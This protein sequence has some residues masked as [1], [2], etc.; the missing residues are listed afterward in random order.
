MFFHHLFI[1]GCVV[2]VGVFAFPAMAFAVGEA[3]TDDSDCAVGEVCANSVCSLR[4]DVTVSVTVPAGAPPP[5]GGGGTSPPTI[6]LEGKAYPNA[7]VTIFRDG[8]VA[9]TALAGLDA[10]FSKQLGAVPA[11]THTF[12]IQ[13]Q[14]EDGRVSRTIEITLSLANGTVTTISNIFLP[15]TIE[16]APPTVP[17]GDTIRIFGYIF[18]RSLVSVFINSAVSQFVAAQDSGRWEY[19]LD[20]SSLALGSHRAKARATSPDGEISD[21]SEVQSFDV[22]SALP[23]PVA[24]PPEPPGPE[25]PAGPPPPEEVAACAHGDLNGDDRVDMGDLS[26]LLFWWERYHECPDQNGDRIV[27]MI[28]VSIMLFWWTD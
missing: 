25:P 15:P 16:V 2:L 7:L 23:P 10:L 1:L 12:G 14:D 5:S 19:L 26:I 4:Q 9:G 18:P 28:D 6:I 27:D 3:C 21:F 17:H 20:T 13:V 8:A 22:V 11:G 24:P